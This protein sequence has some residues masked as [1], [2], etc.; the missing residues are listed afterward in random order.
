MARTARTIRRSDPAFV[1]LIEGDA[2]LSSV[3][4]S[5]GVHWVQIPCYSCEIGV[6]YNGDEYLGC[7][8]RRRDT[9]KWSA[10]PYD[11]H[12]SSRVLFKGAMFEAMAWMED[13]ATRT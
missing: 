10:I 1:W 7:I 3:S 11:P 6:L 4:S 13:H 9:L 8:V 2:L 12:S 5:Q